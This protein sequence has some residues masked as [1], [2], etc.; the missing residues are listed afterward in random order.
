MVFEQSLGLD[1]SEFYD[2]S[3]CF[4]KRIWKIS[5]F[6]ILGLLQEVK[7][8]RIQFSRFVP[9]L[10]LSIVGERCDEN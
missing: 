7:G 3:R 2:K 10:A 6:H 1:L 4:A 9:I 5:L 8:K